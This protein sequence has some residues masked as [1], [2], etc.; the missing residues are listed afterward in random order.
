M[1]HLSFQAL[2]YPYF[3]IGHPLGSVTQDSGKQQ[4]D[5]QAKTGLP[6]YIKPAPPAQPPTKAHTLISSRPN[7][8]SQPPQHFVY[9]YKGEASRADQPSHLQEGKPSPTLFPSLHNKNLQPVSVYKETSLFVSV[10]S[11]LATNT[12]CIRSYTFVSTVPWHCEKALD[13]RSEFSF[14]LFH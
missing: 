12:M 8:T 14:C 9:P 11:L 1:P 7:Q 13:I 4:K 2:R 6:T 10:L 3:Q 5:V